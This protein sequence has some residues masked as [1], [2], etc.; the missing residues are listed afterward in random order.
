MSNYQK[1]RVSSLGLTVDEVMELAETIDPRYRVLILVGAFGSLRIGELAGL[2]VG[3]F[4][5]LRRQIEIRRTASDVSGRIVVGPP[6]TPKSRRRSCNP[7][8]L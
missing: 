2:A 8:S 3:D 1:S 6:K 7:V 5:P 4:D